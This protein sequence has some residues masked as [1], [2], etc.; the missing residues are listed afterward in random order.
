M[1]NRI[2]K[3]I[4]FL[5][6]GFSLYP[7]QKIS[8]NF[9]HFSGKSYDFV[10]F[11]GSETKVLQGTIPDDGKFTLTVPAEYYPYTGMCRWLITGTLEGGGLD[12]II[13]GKDFSVSCLSKQPNNDNILYEGNTQP[14]KLNMLYSRQQEIFARHD[15]M[16]QAIRAYPKTDKNYH[17]F[18]QEYHY[19]L[20]TFDSFQSDLNKEASY[21]S[22]FLKITNITLGIGTRIEDSEEKKADNIRDYIVREM[23]W[24]ILYNSGHWYSVINSWADIHTRVIKD[25]S[26]FAGDFISISQ[27]ISKEAI[28]ADFAKRVAAILSEQGKDDWIDIIAP[29]VSTS[30]KIDKYEGALAAYKRIGVDLQA[31][32][33][34]FRKNLKGKEED[35]TLKSTELTG[36]DYKKTLLVFYDSNCGHC[37]GLL[38][39][40]RGKYNKLKSSGVRVITISSDMDK[41]T[42]ETKSRDFPWKDVYCDYMGLKGMNFINYGITGTPSLVLLDHEG[43]IISR[44]AELMKMEAL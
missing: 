23:N 13:P 44:A 18:E 26:K 5:L 43:K 42:F 2:A 31:P 17:L 27:K 1:M 15:A 30:G 19:Q 37:S 32:D 39:E 33:L 28:Y 3:L 10:L 40:L 9:P 35:F 8:M 29:V 16:L 41:Y 21:A 20:K 25:K 12:M 22:E 24:E 4:F 34:I 11:F 36:K 14:D 38:K 7:A 6:V